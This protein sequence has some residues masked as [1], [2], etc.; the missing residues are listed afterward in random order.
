MIETLR[1]SDS[2]EPYHMQLHLFLVDYVPYSFFCYF[3]ALV[4]AWFARQIWLSINPSLTEQHI[5]LQKAYEQAIADEKN[6]KLEGEQLGGNPQ[7]SEEA[8][9]GTNEGLRERKKTVKTI[10]SSKDAAEKAGEGANVS[11]PSSLSKPPRAPT[12]PMMINHTIQYWHNMFLVV[13]SAG[14]IFNCVIL[15]HQVAHTADLKAGRTGDAKLSLFWNFN[16]ILQY[17]IESRIES[18]VFKLTMTCFLLNK[19]YEALDTVILVLNGKDLLLLHVWHHATTYIAFYQGCF[20]GACLW[21]GVLNSFIHVVMYLYYAKVAWVIPIAKWITSLQIF[22]LFGGFICNAFTFLYCPV[23]T[24]DKVIH[25]TVGPILKNSPPRIIDTIVPSSLR[26]GIAKFIGF[27]HSEV[28][29]FTPY[30]TGV[31]QNTANKIPHMGFVNGFICFS[32]F[33][34]FLAFFSKKYHKNGNI[35]KMFKIPNAVPEV[36]RRV[37]PTGVVEYMKKQGLL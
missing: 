13:Q 20:T 16:Q 15:F 2:W 35:W 10:D 25:Y 32:Y 23:S 8:S 4:V 22:H 28:L 33:F 9:G 3:L 14:L 27:F 29:G 5:E 30:T 7:E 21:I 19:I 11:K 31:Y 6:K 26:P 12:P 24:A 36:I 1:L 17:E 18:P 37:L 34:L